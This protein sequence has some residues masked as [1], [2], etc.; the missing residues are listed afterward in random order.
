MDLDMDLDP[1]GSQAA[2]FKLYT[3]LAFVYPRSESASKPDIISIMDRGLEHL[4]KSFPWV[5]GQVV[6]TNTNPAATPKYKI[7]PLNST[8]ELLIKDYTENPSVPSFVQLEEAE[9]PMNMLSEDVWAPCAT[10]A[11]L[12][13]DPSSPSGGPNKIAPVM[14]VQLSFIEGGLVLCINLQHNVCDMMGQAAI[15][16]WLSK[17][18]RGENFTNHEIQ[19]GQM[20]RTT[21]V[22]LIGENNWNPGNLLDDQILAPQNTPEESDISATAPAPDVAVP[23]TLEPP[24]CSWVYFNF[25]A[26]ALA[27]LKTFASET[28]PPNSSFIST[29]D[30][31]SAFIFQ[32]VLRVRKPRLNQQRSVRFARAVDARRYMDVNS[33]YPGILQNM[34][35]T[36]YQLSELLNTP[37]GHIAAAMREKVDPATSDVALRTR[38]LITY[39]AQ[40]PENALK[41]SF[42]ARLKTDADIMLS[43]WA[44]IAA[45]EW[46]FGLGLGRP[47][48]V[49][50]PG[51]LPVESLMYIMPK[52][53]KGGIAVGMCLR[54]DDLEKLVEDIEWTKFA[55][56]IG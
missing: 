48:A 10:L 1:M 12:S 45:F 5:A 26:T 37:L 42:T 38:A 35:Y 3:Q 47:K 50:R 11:G 34:T 54:K 43:S 20:D 28:L 49:R 9:F 56:F 40:S 32:S 15:M 16:E 21:T 39:L 29:D 27:G 41:V 4:S 55:T 36:S 18:C 31:I 23:E 13:Y 46:D 24:V 17:A 6:N 7:R 30:A 33:K 22:P 8:P 19:L 44:K 2:L 53:K 52:D 25:S 14:L 51:F